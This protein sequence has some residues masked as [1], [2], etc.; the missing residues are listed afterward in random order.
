MTKIKNFTPHAI[1]LLSSNI[2]PLRDFPSDGI[3]RVTST[4]TK[5]GDL[6]GIP[7]TTTTFGEVTGLPGKKDGTFIIVSR[8]LCAACPHRDDLLIVDQTVRNDVGRIIGC[9]SFAKNPN[10]VG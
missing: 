3:A 5:V 8:L 6:D 1:N 7:I 9:T 10:F 4:T 2:K